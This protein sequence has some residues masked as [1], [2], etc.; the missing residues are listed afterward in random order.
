[1]ILRELYLTQIEKS[2]KKI[3]MSRQ[4]MEVFSFF[5]P[6]ARPMKKAG[7]SMA[8]LV[9][10]RLFS[11]HVCIEAPV[12]SCWQLTFRNTIGGAIVCHENE[13]GI[14]SKFQFFE[15]FAQ[16]AYVVINI[17][18]HAIKVCTVSPEDGISVWFAPLWINP[19]W[20]MWSIRCEI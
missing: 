3:K 19:V 16:Q 6:T 13:N 14:F 8:T 17:C 2:W 9:H 4:S 10:S 11:P 15:V 5:E 20:S 7:D 1:M 18:N 12:T